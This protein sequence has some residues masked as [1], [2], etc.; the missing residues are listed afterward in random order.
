MNC[1]VTDI[2]NTIADTRDRLRRSLEE[3]DR[4]E[5]YGETADRYGGFGEYLD[6]EEEE[7]FWNL[8]LSNRFL[9]LDSPAP[10]AAKFLQKI[11]DEGVKII[12]L[13]GRHDEEGDSMRPGTESW[14]EEY[15]FPSPSV[16]GV[17]LFMKP[18]RKTNDRKFKLAKLQKEF[19]E[20]SRLKEI[21]GIGDHPDDALVYNRVGIR[22]V[23]LDWL[24]LF[25]NQELQNSASGVK[26][27]EDWQEL[28]R[29]FYGS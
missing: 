21:I 1:F 20:K 18:R 10:G 13:T 22:S 3:I 27:V 28:E 7:R 26:I 17:K 9:H 14:L 11:K 25:S 23:L 15:G 16:T 19:S 8:F 2:D 4:V 5:V 12:Y 29:E 6:E 24:G